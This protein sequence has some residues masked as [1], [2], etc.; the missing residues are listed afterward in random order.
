MAK[1]FVNLNP[2]KH[3][4]AIKQSSKRRIA[5]QSTSRGKRKGHG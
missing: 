3:G 4:R 5:K 1:G 2:F